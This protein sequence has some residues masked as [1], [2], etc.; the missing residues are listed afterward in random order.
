MSRD[1]GPPVFSGLLIN[2]IFEF[3]FDFVE[4]FDHRDVSVMCNILQRSSQRC[5]TYHGDH[6]RGVQHSVEIISV[7]CN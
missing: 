5:A 2:N 6:L 4:I 1:F 7:V 3:S